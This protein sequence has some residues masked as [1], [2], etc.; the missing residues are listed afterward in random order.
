[1]RRISY[2]QNGEDVRVWHA[3]HDGPG[4]GEG[5]PFTY[6]DIGAN[7]P[8]TLSIT[9]SL[10]DLGWRGLLVEADPE[11]AHELRA[12]RPGDIVEQAAAGAQ[13]GSL[14]FYR[15]P[16]TGLGTL[17]A[18]EAQAARARG[19][20]VVE[21]PVPTWTVDEMLDRHGLVEVH[22]M[23]IDVEGAEADVLRGLQ[24]HRP[25]VMC[26]EAVKPGTAEPSHQEW[27]SDLLTKGY[28]YAAFDGVNRW[29]VRND[30][31]ELLEPIATPLNV[32]DT[33]SAGWLTAEQARL[34]DRD[35]RQSIRSAWQRELLLN[36]ARNQVDPRATAQQ[37]HELRS[38]LAG[39]EASRFWRWTRPVARI[40]R[41][42]KYRLQ[43]FMQALPKGI[44]Q[45]IIRERH[46]RLVNA[47]QQNL[48]DPAYLGNP[49]AEQVEWITPDGLPELPDAAALHLAPLDA[50]GVQA[51]QTWLAAGPYDSDAMLVRRTDNHGDELG[52]VAAAL[53]LRLAIAG[54]PSSD[55]QPSSAP[56]GGSDVLFDARSLQTAAFGTRGIG[57]FARSALLATRQALG[58]DR[59]VLLIDPARDR[60]PV[61]LA[62][63]CRQVRH[64]GQAKDYAVLVQPSPMTASAEPLLDV[65]AGPAL[66]IAIVYDFIPMHYPTIYLRHAATRLEYAAALDALRHYDAFIS[67]SHDTQGELHRFLGRTPARSSVAWPVGIMP[68][69]APAARA[70]ADGPIVI[71][72]G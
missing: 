59:C 11:L 28:R 37:I 19:Y 38:A 71:M 42:V 40:A 29:Y 52:R 13:S 27:E 60:L 26:V 34:Q 2:A 54:L 17:D 3:F 10:Y 9:A 68:T 51:A 20:E 7:E 55:T 21:T 70:S 14:T 39:V 30:K 25:W 44:R 8:R 53:R 18:R 16:G 65:L 58:D 1:M 47:N 63:Q 23:S 49:P 36:Q 5:S 57:R 32:I 67:I 33:G 46:L 15:V 64:P 48:V 24:R 41:A 69:T 50:A 22:F 66:S 12:Q 56:A 45:R 35:D 61:E 31:P 62:G 4:G 6:V 43:R 72:T